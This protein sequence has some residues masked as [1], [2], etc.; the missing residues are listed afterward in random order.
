MWSVHILA[1]FPELFPGPLASSITGRAL[2]EAIWEIKA[3]DV[4][5]Y[6]TDKHKTVDDCPYG[7]GG[8]MV[9]RPD[10][11]GQAIEE[12]F[13][14][15]QNE[16]IYLS[17]RGELFNQGL[18]RELTQR[19]GINI[20][21]GRFEGIDERVINEYRI[22]EVSI[23]DFVLSSGD[24]AAYSLLDACV[25]L[26]PRV[27]GNDSSLVQESFGLDHNYEMLLE[28]PHFTRPQNWRDRQVP[29]VLLS[30]NH[31]LIENW[32]LEQAK[33]KTKEQRPDLWNRYLNRKGK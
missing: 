25:R 24:I 4:R 20:I 15:N 19:K 1:L 5:N 17:P 7:G 27:L 14:S 28:Y 3:I 29:E 30:G 8:G 23:G 10:I 26:L 11:L 2:K 33:Q 32:R 18:A 13:I 6:A 12:N 22:R 16:I 31:Q 9:I 21:C